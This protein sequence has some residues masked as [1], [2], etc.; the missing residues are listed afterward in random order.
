MPVMYTRVWIA[1]CEAVSRSTFYQNIIIMKKV[2]LYILLAFLPA[3]AMAQQPHYADVLKTVAENNKTLKAAAMLRDAQ[4]QE[5]RVGTLLPNPEVEAA[6]YWGS[7]AEVGKRWDLSVSQSIDMPSVLVRKAR[8][9]NLQD[10]AADI[11]YDAKLAQQLYAAQQ[12][13]AD[14][15]YYRTVARLWEGRTAMAFRL[16]DMYTSRL[17]AGDCSI[18]EYNR[19]QMYNAEVQRAAAE[20]LLNAAHEQNQLNI[21]T[22][23]PHYAFSQEAYDEVDLPGNFGPWY[24]QFEMQNPEFRMLKSQLDISQQQAQLSRAEWLPQVSVGYASENVV[25]ETF[26]GVTLGATFPIW[27]QPRAAK[28]AKLHAQAVGEELNS[29]RAELY[30]E[31]ECLF[32]HL[33]SLRQ[34]IDNLKSAYAKFG[35]LDLLQKALEAGEVSLETYLQQ[36]DA[37]VDVELQIIELQ[38]QFELDWLKLN[39]INL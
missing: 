37:C 22:G 21:I 14:M 5:V 33:Y 7:P 24:E 28:A 25:G 9:R 2:C 20:A 29:M 31:M 10:T 12:I 32:H 34:N 4:K 11:S 1:E 30:T 15:I 36:S 13:C 3:L 38:H 23:S 19:V 8:I 17:E 16:V 6:Y 35:S 27:S 26:R 39:S 18:L